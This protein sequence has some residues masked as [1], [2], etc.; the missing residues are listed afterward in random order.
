MTNGSFATA[1]KTLTDKA[2]KAMMP[3]YKTMIQ[4]QMP[5]HKCKQLFNTFIE[6]ILLYNAENW[7]TMTDK[8]IR[9][10]REDSNKIYEMASKTLTTTAQLKFYKFMM[11]VNKSCPNLA[12]F[13]D[14]GELPLQLKAYI[15][16]LK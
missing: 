16:M 6:P 7:S 15:I 3:L 1:I 12:I 11:G 9:E 13:G 14:T 4:F 10:C 2:K 8:Q 5:F